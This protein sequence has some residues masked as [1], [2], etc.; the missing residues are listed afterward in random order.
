MSINIKHSSNYIYAL[1]EETAYASGKGSTLHAE[2][3]LAAGDGSLVGLFSMPLPK[4]AQ[5]VPILDYEKE[6][7][8]SASLGADTVILFTKGYKYGDLSLTHYLQTLGSE[9]YWLDKALGSVTAGSIPTSWC[10]HLEDGTFYQDVMGMVIKEYTLDMSSADEFPTEA[11]S[12]LYYSIKDS[13]TGSATAVTNLASSKPFITTAPK[14]P[15]EIQLSIDGDDV[16]DYLTKLSLKVTY[17][18]EDTKVAGRYGRFDP[19]LKSRDVELSITLKADPS[20]QVRVPSSATSNLITVVLSINGGTNTYTMT[21][22]QTMESNAGDVPEF[23]LKDF[24][25][26]LTNGGSSTYTKA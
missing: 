10:L 17:E 15:K 23:G 2:E 9:V 3:V 26:M 7:I 22:F 25:L 12:F 11:I 18:Y 19:Y 8:R 13:L 6:K 21:N 1:K 4:D 14:I 24:E 16:T 20:G 5:T